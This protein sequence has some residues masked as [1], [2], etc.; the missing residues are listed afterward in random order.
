MTNMHKSLQD[1]VSPIVQMLRDAGGEIVGRTKLQKAAYLLS[2]AGF[3]TRF[4]FGYKHY[5][6]FSE[7][8][9]DAAELAAAFGLISEK[10]QPASWGGTYSVYT[11][12]EGDLSVQESR[13]RLTREAA[14]SDAVLLELAATAAYLAEEGK[15]HPWEET[16]R[17]KPDKAADGRI[18][19]AKDLYARLRKASNDSLPL[20]SE[21]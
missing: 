13:I 12:P 6:P 9:A 14:S 17:R 15:P 8:L 11:A 4:R 3:E 16:S 2:L 18:D 1:R 20:V 7:E 19:R 10:Q 21:S 5:G